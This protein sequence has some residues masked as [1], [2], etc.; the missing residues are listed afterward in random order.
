MVTAEEVAIPA[1]F[2]ESIRHDDPRLFRAG[3]TQL[4]YEDTA[5]SVVL[6]PYESFT[7]AASFAGQIARKSCRLINGIRDGKPQE[8]RIVQERVSL[9]QGLSYGFQ[10]SWQGKGYKALTRPID[11]SS[12]RSPGLVS[13][14]S[15]ATRWLC[16]QMKESQDHAAAGDAREAA[17]LLGRCKEVAAADP[18]CDQHLREGISKLPDKVLEMSGNIV[19]TSTQ[20]LFF[21]TAAGIFVVGLC[22]GLI[23]NVAFPAVLATAA[24]VVLLVF[25]VVLGRSQADMA[26]NKGV[27]SSTMG[28]L[29]RR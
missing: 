3:A 26:S 6:S 23:M 25:G 2:A 19:F 14:V 12:G 1:V 20:I 27:W 9:F 21:S 4:V 15:P 8:S 11:A 10:Y 5:D 16:E 24:A 22:L 7:S 29:R 18:T 13:H 28:L 17:L